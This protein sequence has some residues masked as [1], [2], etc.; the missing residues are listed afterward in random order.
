ML[1]T[2][3]HRIEFGPNGQDFASSFFWL[4]LGIALWPRHEFS[5]A[6]IFRAAEFEPRETMA[7]APSPPDLQKLYDFNISFLIFRQKK[8]LSGNQR[9]LRPVESNGYPHLSFRDLGD[10]LAELA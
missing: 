1:R 7:C 2:L 6:I 5:E 8:E 3:I 9:H 4:L 10:G